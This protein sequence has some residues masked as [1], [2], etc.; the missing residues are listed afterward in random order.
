VIALLLGILLAYTKFIAF[1]V[2]GTVKQK[3]SL[4]ALRMNCSLVQKHKPLMNGEKVVLPPLR[5]NLGFMKNSVRTL[6]DFDILK[7]FSL[8]WVKQKSKT[9][10]SLAHK[11]D[12]LCR[13]THLN[14]P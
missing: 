4:Y 5:D 11:L 2:S 1:C 10:F 3:K 7:L 6:M 14:T 12:T 9:L 8:E 13:T